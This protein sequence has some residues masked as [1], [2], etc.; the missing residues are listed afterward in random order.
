[1]RCGQLHSKQVL[2]AS[3]IILPLT[4]HTGHVTQAAEELGRGIRLRGEGARSDW[5]LPE[6]LLEVSQS[7]EMTCQWPCI[8]WPLR[9]QGSLSRI[10]WRAGSRGAEWKTNDTEREEEEKNGV[11]VEGR[12]TEGLCREALGGVKMKNKTVG[13]RF[14]WAPGLSLLHKMSDEKI[15]F[16]STKASPDGRCKPTPLSFHS[17]FLVPFLLPFLVHCQAVLRL[18]ENII[19]I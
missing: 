12:H 7:A 19:Q 16:Y 8:T 6:V 15:C 18:A 4:P 1:M 2:K 3:L 10:S 9:A 17:L 5:L 11:R 14:D 13:V